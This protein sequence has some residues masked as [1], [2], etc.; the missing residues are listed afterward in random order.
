M[1]FTAL[2]EQDF[3]GADFWWISWGN[4]TIECIVT[5]KNKIIVYL[6]KIEQKCFFRDAV[7]VHLRVKG[8]SGVINPHFVQVHF[9]YRFVEKLND[10]LKHIFIFF[11]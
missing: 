10:F 6:L 1:W 11:Y 9:T 5:V 8:K 2:V 7:D 4:G 3:L